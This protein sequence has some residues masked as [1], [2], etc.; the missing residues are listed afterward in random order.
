M[1][2][3]I[4]LSPLEKGLK[5]YDE[6]L[7]TINKSMGLTE[8]GMQRLEDGGKA[9]ANS[10][11]YLTARSKELQ[12]QL[13][14]LDPATKKFNDTAKNLNATLADL[15][16]VHDKAAKATGSWTKAMDLGTVASKGMAVALGMLGVQTVDALVGPERNGVT[17]LFVRATEHSG[18]NTNANQQ[19][20][21]LQ[22]AA[23][24]RN[25]LHRQW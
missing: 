4:Y 18:G 24:S 12:T 11:E 2:A 10:I 13:N 23:S 16:A 5:K 7:A 15:K 14:Q 22:I 8:K 1:D 19:H 17:H 20:P 21:D 9:T 6:L 25:P 3:E